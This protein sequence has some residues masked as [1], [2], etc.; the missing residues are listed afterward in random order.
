MDLGFSTIILKLEIF[1][2]L[3]SLVYAVY[4]LS[5]RIIYL[6][7]YVKWI[8]KP[9]RLKNID[10]K[11]VQVKNTFDHKEYKEEVKK[12]WDKEKNQIRDLLKRIKLNKSRWEIE[13][14]RNLIIEALT[15]D[16]I[17]RDVN[18]ELAS[19]YIDENDYKKAEFIY[20][21]LLLV[22][23]NDFDV[24]KKLW[25]VLS[26]QDKYE[27]AIEVYKKAYSLNRN[28]MEI[29][30][31]LAYLFFTVWS[32]LE[33]ITYFKKYLKERPRDVESL[34]SLSEV[35]KKIGDFKESVVTLK[36]ALDI[37]P[38][39]EYIHKELKELETPEIVKNL[40]NN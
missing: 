32:F 39:N 2:L 17:N 36:R 30:N 29:V 35:Y 37:N 16:K 11:K 1:A 6:T 33:S 15:I 20:K 22:Y 18:I 9:Q 12:I 23:P 10:I 13:I 24:L 25:F 19:L 26:N 28:D 40:E 21:D 38:Y 31:M 3:I 34:I 8:I 4:Y 5:S 27:L 14:A 7:R